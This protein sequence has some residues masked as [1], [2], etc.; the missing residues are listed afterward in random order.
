MYRHP[1]GQSLDEDS[2]SDQDSLVITLR[3]EKSYLEHKVSKL[4]TKVISLEGE[5]SLS[6][7][8]YV[9]LLEKL[10]SLQIVPA[11][12][13]A[14]GSCST[15]TMDPFMAL[16]KDVQ[17]KDNAP[18][19][20]WDRFPEI[21]YWMKAN[22]LKD[23]QIG[24]E[25]FKTKCDNNSGSI[26]F[27]EDENGMVI[28]KEDQQCM[29]DHQQALCYTL[30]KFGL[31]PITWSRIT[32][33]ARPPYHNIKIVHALPLPSNTSE[34]ISSTPPTVL[35]LM[36]STS[37]QTVTVPTTSIT[38][39]VTSPTPTIQ[40]TAPTCTTTLPPS[41]QVGVLEELAA[42]FLT[43]TDLLSGSALSRLAPNKA[44][45]SIDTVQDTTQKPTG[46]RKRKAPDPNLVMRPD[47][48]STST[49]NLYSV[50][51]CKQNKKGTCGQYTEHWSTL[52]SMKDLLVTDHINSN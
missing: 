33:L 13:G 45:E 29:H 26:S 36:S 9:Q 24:R 34:P 51:W 28:S 7:K 27:M 46:K 40:A 16:L 31:A 1:Q 15:T 22:Y 25:Y 12:S 47:G 43:Q 49:R 50:E 18:Y 38:E 44:L 6:H 2:Q 11:N 4:E 19:E 5:L 32:E 3:R 8:L 48:K 42:A 20:T 52:I 39:L 41:L 37:S 14:S 30:L 10:S 35:A 17:E 23:S 21:V